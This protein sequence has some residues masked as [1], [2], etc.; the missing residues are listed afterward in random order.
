MR[1][2]KPLRRHQP[3]SGSPSCA[4]GF[5]RAASLS[6]RAAA[7]AANS[8]GLEVAARGGSTIAV[9]FC[10]GT[11]HSASALYKPSRATGWT[12]TIQPCV[13]EKSMSRRSRPRGYSGD[14]QRC[15]GQGRGL[16]GGG[17][18]L[19]RGGGGAHPQGAARRWCRDWFGLTHSDPATS[20][21]G[22]IGTRSTR[23]GTSHFDPP[24][25]WADPGKVDTANAK[26]PNL[27][28]A[29]YVIRARRAAR[30][31]LK[32][33]RRPSRLSLSRL[34]ERFVASKAVNFD[35]KQV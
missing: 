9:K 17:G 6:R 16:A 2:W 34:L 28:M 21:N 4:A 24:F 8:R 14:P 25:T 5:W 29:A 27:E 32:L 19:D 26:P 33:G 11:T 30:R 13:R 15:R 10:A 3:H 35:L 22:R 12:K 18:Q 23:S 20:A 31:R 1:I 7:R